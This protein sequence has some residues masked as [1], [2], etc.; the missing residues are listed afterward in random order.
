MCYFQAFFVNFSVKLI[1]AKTLNMQNKNIILGITGGIAAYKSAE[2]VRRLYKANYNVRVVMTKNAKEFITPLTLQTLSCNTVY[3]E[4]FDQNL[5]AD[6]QHI[7]LARWADAILIAPASANFL[8]RLAYGFADDL[9]T[10]VCLAT[11]API[12]VAPAMNKEMWQKMITQKNI[13]TLKERGIEIF[14]P[15]CG[16]LA[17]KEI[18]TGKMLEAAE[19]FNLLNAACAPKILSGKKVLITAGPTFEAIDPVRYLGNH[20]SGRMGYALAAAAFKASAD[21]TL[22]SGPVNLDCLNKIKKIKVTTALEMQKAVLTEIKACDIFISCAA[23]SDFRPKKTA[24]NKIKKSKDGL[25]L[26]LIKNPDILAEVAKIYTG[27][28]KPFIVGFAAETENLATN[29]LKKLQ[30]K[31]L[32]M[33]VANLVGKNLGFGNVESELLVLQKNV[34]PIEI[35]RATKAA[36]AS[37]LIEIIA[38]ASAAREN[39]K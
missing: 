14:G 9:L 12:F 21:V 2:L 18:G 23:V 37:R 16:E 39:K 27:A 30:Q 38:E 36:L 22:I 26:A 32:D 28:K 29:S 11:T 3:S 13:A 33:I 20:S 17:C 7:A 19:L 15:A 35:A 24:T 4:M 5:R 34:A 10:T 31:N 1:E 6:I 25:T 8:A